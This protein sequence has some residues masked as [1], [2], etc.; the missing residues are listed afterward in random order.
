MT[1]ID[2]SPLAKRLAEE[3]N[4][5]WQ[6]LRGSGV[7]GKI[8]ERDV[9]EYL[10]RVMS[11]QE[12]LDPTPEPLPEGMEEWP[13]EDI[14]AYRR[15]ARE[16]AGAK[17]SGP[18]TPPEASHTVQDVIDEDIFLFEDDDLEVPTEREPDVFAVSGGDEIEEDEDLFLDLPGGEDAPAKTGGGRE[19][20]SAWLTG[21][22]EAEESVEEDD[23]DLG[24]M[25]FDVS[26][27][28]PPKSGG[29]AVEHRDVRH[30]D[31][32][33]G[34]DPEP[35]EVEQP[36]PEPEPEPS[37]VVT[38]SASEQAWK[39][40]E[41]PM[42]RVGHLFRRHVD[43]TALENA[44]AVLGR[45]L[46]KDEPVELSVFLVR[47]AAKAMRTHSLGQGGLSLATV[48]NGLAF[49]SVDD[50]A[51]VSFGDLVAS[52]GAADPADEVSAGTALVVVDLSSLGVDEAVLDVGVPV[53]ALGRMLYD[54]HA[55]DVRGTLS[56][57]GEIAPEPAGR[58]LA[59]VAD[60]LAAPVRLVI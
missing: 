9:L 41:I 36:K 11:G 4:V 55:G 34:G 28:E 5:D 17:S 27:P 49:R 21:E 46:G 44:Q 7:D 52:V 1:D 47:A 19:D 26:E 12:D 3:N 39:S 45:E 58:L 31:V 56:L 48:E 40:G 25:A 8:V 30:L 18:A 15:A 60:L 53:L 22:S 51:E 29:Y 54:D 13:D 38:R 35:E 2:I 43:L 6:R 24:A 33:G 10:A 59:A 16:R 50:A 14:A 23:F 32:V 42:V 20:S 57:S 37:H